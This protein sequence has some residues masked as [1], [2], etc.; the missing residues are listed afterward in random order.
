MQHNASARLLDARGLRPEMHRDA[1][2]LERLLERL[3][4][5]GILVGD[6]MRH[7]LDDRHL[8]A[9][10]VEDRCELAADHAT[11]E[12]QE[13][14]GHFR[15][16]EQA[17][18]V[19][20]LGR[21][22]TFNGRS[23]GMRASGDDGALE[24]HLL[25]TLHH[26]RVRSREAALAVDDG[27][28]VGLEQATN[29]GDEPLDDRVLVLLDLIEVERRAR[30]VD[31][32]VSKRLRR[33]LHRMRG[34]NP[35]LRRNAADV[36]T[37]TSEIALLDQRDRKTELRRPDRRRIATGSTT[38]HRNVNIHRKF[39]LLFEFPRRSEAISIPSGQSNP[40]S[41]RRR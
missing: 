3:D 41:P 17:R 24:V 38:E 10:V 34:L 23:H 11:A 35:R 14:L 33:V 19:D 8:A 25:T 16:G 12:H 36:K 1:V 13:A 9:E 29:A 5:I 21:V 31:A 28:A 26:D 4:R 2:A 20:A 40:R 6:E 39:R 37:G 15:D 18:R 30:D 32:Q 7:E 27:D 22:D